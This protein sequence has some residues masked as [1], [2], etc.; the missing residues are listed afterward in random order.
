[1]RLLIYAGIARGRVRNRKSNPEGVSPR[2]L[3][4][5]SHKPEYIVTTNPDRS[6]LIP[7]ITWHFQFRTVN[8]GILHLIRLSCSKLEPFR[9]LLPLLRPVVPLND[10]NCRITMPVDKGPCARDA[11]PHAYH[12]DV[13]KFIFTIST[14]IKHIYKESANITEGCNVACDT[15]VAGISNK[16][17]QWLP[18]RVW[19]HALA[20]VTHEISWHRAYVA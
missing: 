5:S 20:L 9:V 19:W 13:F 6:A 3:T 7:I 17:C 1:M 12:I 14:A 11:L 18:L 15:K 4:Y 10:G 8:V 16:R 2:D